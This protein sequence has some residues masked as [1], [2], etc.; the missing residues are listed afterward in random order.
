MKEG[1]WKKVMKPGYSFQPRELLKRLFNTAPVQQIWKSIFRQSYPDTDKTRLQVMTN[2]FL[3]HWHP[4]RV[5]AHTLKP[6]YTLGLG[7]ITFFLYVLLIGTGGILMFF[8]IPSV[9]RA[10]SDIQNLHT[11]VTFGALM[12]NMHRWGAHLMVLAVF[13]HM[14]RVFYTGGYKQPR[15]LNWVMGVV[16][17]A[18]TLLLSFT[19]YLLVWDQLSFWAITV[20][21][22][23]AGA[24]PV[25]GYWVRLVL[26]G[27]PE[28]SQSSLLNF[29]VLHLVVLPI[30]LTTLLGFH[31]WRV[32]KDGGLSAPLKKEAE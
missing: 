24:S 15:E 16:I 32:R 6:S 22:N 28:V 3:F 4:G 18:I 21:T 13:A 25:I 14:A 10:Y 2:T 29:W 8:Y 5:K 1:P 11:Q 17:L 31:F 9:D 12:R 26:L 20:G 30:A 27:A 7:L 19:G 23:M